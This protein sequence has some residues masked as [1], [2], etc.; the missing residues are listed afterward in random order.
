MLYLL[1]EELSPSAIAGG[2]MANQPWF[3]AQR[4][5]RN[6]QVCRDMDSH[7]CCCSPTCTHRHR[8]GRVT[9]KVRGRSAQ[10]KRFERV[11]AIADIVEAAEAQWPPSGRQRRQFCERQARPRASSST[12]IIDPMQRAC[13]ATHGAR[14]HVGCCA[15][16]VSVFRHRAPDALEPRGRVLMG[17]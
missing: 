3:R 17:A 9:K 15:S 14:V 6:I 1:L 11:H 4:Y 7:G 16:N 12:S 2:T 5:Q 10:H 13:L 8:P